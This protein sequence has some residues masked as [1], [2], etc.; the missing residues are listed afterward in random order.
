M[1]MTYGYKK[2]LNITKSGYCMSKLI[3][4]YL[5]FNRKT[6]FIREMYKITSFISFK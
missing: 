6:D 1:I 2:I 4:L 5:H 3:L